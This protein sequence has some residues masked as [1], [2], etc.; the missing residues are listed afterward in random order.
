MNWLLEVPVFFRYRRLLKIYF[1][2]FRQGCWFFYPSIYWKN[3]KEEFPMNIPSWAC[4]HFLKKALGN[5]LYPQDNYSAVSASL[6][7]WNPSFT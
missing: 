1:I 6:D 7:I 4:Q 2:L 5:S 3:S